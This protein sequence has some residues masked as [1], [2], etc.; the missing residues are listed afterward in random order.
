VSKRATAAG[1][2]GKY[3]FILSSFGGGRGIRT[4]GGLAAPAVFK[5]APINR[6]GIPPR[7]AS[8]QFIGP[9]RV[10]P[11]DISRRASG[12]LSSSGMRLG[13]AVR[14]PFRP[15][16]PSGRLAKVGR[17]SRLGSVASRS[18]GHALAMPRRLRPIRAQPGE[19]L[20]MTTPRDPH[21]HARASANLKPL[22]DGLKT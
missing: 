10:W 1:Q 9:G 2:A 15:C 18:I 4:P 13:L 12:D 8:S 16:M 6:S 20:P 7:G 19:A 11:C 17:P 21:G 5:T 3:S 14:G 22:V